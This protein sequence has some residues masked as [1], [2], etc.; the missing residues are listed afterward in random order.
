MER[1]L[2]LAKRVAARYRSGHDYDDLVQVASFALIK[3]I[4]RYDPDRGLAFS[5]FA[6]PTIVGELKRYF[7]DH[8]WA[9]RVPRDLQDLA[10]KVQRASAQLMSASDGRPRPPRS[11]RSWTAASSSCSKPSRPRAPTFPTALTRPPTSS[12]PPPHSHR[13]DDRR[14]DTKSPRR[15]PCWGPCS[16]DWRLVEQQIVHLRFEE[17]LTQTEIGDRLGVSQMHVSRIL[18]KAMADLQRFAAEG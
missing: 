7:R 17:D 10:L 4:D 15:Q 12:I 9:V 16:L 2:P 14:R 13:C 18:R 6:V 3:A 8:T 5:S 1:F 11:P